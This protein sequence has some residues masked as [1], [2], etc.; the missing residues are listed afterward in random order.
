MVKHPEEHVLCLAE[1]H[2]TFPSSPTC[3]ENIMWGRMQS[4]AWYCVLQEKTMV[5]N[6]KNAQQEK[7]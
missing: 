1:D 3:T 4:L 7:P 2:G 6:N 5:L